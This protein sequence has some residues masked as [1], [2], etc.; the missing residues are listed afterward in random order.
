MHDNVKNHSKIRLI[1]K[2]T[3]TLKK[4]CELTNHEIMYCCEESSFILIKSLIN[5][6]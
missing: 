6:L 1:K 2:Y 3:R 5:L 4:N